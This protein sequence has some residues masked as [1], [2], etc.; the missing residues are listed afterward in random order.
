VGTGEVIGGMES[1]PVFVY[2]AVLPGPLT[3]KADTLYYFSIMNNTVYDVD[4]RWYWASSHEGDHA[5]W[6][7]TPPMTGLWVAYM[8]DMAFELCGSAASL[9]CRADMDGNRV[10][11]GRDLAMLLSHW[12]PCGLPIPNIFVGAEPGITVPTM[13]NPLDDPA[14]MT[15]M[16]R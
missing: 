15:V 9:D 13:K 14:E 16:Q 2:V 5:H 1:L 8:D 7:R 11:D 12:G 6:H 10:T 4:D 3:L